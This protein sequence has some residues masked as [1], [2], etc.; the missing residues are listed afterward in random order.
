[1]SSE[2]GDT[3]ALWLFAELLLFRPTLIF[4]RENKPI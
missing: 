1:M 2:L 3:F 4:S